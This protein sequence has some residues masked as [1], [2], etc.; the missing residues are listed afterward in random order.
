M[1]GGR[2]RGTSSWSSDPG[3]TMAFAFSGEAVGRQASV[4]DELLDVAPR[5]AGR[6]G[7]EAVHPRRLAVGDAQRPRSGGDGAV[8]HRPRRV[9]VAAQAEH[10]REERHQDEQQDRGAHGGVG[11]VEG[12]EAEVA[13]AHVDP[14]DD[15]AETEPVDQVAERAA[16]QQPERDREVEAPARPAVVPDDQ[17][18]DPERHDPEH[19]RLV[20]EDP[21]E[22][23]GVLAE[24]EPQVVAEDAGWPRPG[25]S[26][27]RARPWSAGR[28]RRPRPRSR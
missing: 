25:R 9:A 4:G 12:P 5:Q 22:R 7:H 28:G 21:E 15:V 3:S 14:V 27:R 26:R 20:A 16:E 1:S 2:P 10:D 18:H 6:I 11:D 23:P 19:E 13:D 17:R 24:D 8:R